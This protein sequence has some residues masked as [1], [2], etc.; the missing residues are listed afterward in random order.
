[1][2]SATEVVAARMLAIVG[3][4]LVLAILA[5][6][7]THDSCLDRSQVLLQYR[8]IRCNRIPTVFIEA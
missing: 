7:S 2:A 1:M 6:Q 8:N 3:S 4:E 5:T